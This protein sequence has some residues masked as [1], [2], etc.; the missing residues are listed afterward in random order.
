MKKKNII[1]V[2]LSL[3]VLSNTL[4]L[5]KNQETTM[6]S[7]KAIETYDMYSVYVDDNATY[8]YEYVPYLGIIIAGCETL[9]TELVFPDEIG[10]LPVTYINSAGYLGYTPVVDSTSCPNLKS[11]VIPESVTYV[12]WF[13]LNGYPMDITIQNPNTWLSLQ[14]NFNDITIHGYDDCSLYDTILSSGEYGMEYEIKFEPLPD[15]RKV[16]DNMKY[17]VTDENTIKIVQ[18]DESATEVN[19]PS[20]IDGMP[21][22]DVCSG[23]FWNCS[24]LASVTI[25]DSIVNI[26]NHAFQGCD[27][28]SVTI[29][30]SVKNI[31]IA[32]FSNCENLNSAVLPDNIES[33]GDSVF[34]DCTSLNSIV[35]PDGVKRIGKNAF[36]NCTSLTNISIPNSVTNIEDEAFYGCTSLTNIGISDSVTNIG[37]Y[38]FSGCTFLTSVTIPDSVTNIGNNAFSEC[39]S[40]TSITIPDSVKS[41]GYYV[42][43]E[44]P[45]LAD[46]Q[47]FVHNNVLIEV[48]RALEG[49][50]II[51]DKVTEI[52][53]NAL[54]ECSS[55]TSVIIPDSVTSIGEFAFAN[56]NLTEIKIP[57]SVTS[58]GN[59]AFEYCRS[60]KSVIL[61]NSVT[62]IGDSVF[63]SCYSL[64]T[65]TIPDSV[66]NIG[67]YA[68]AFSG[69]TII[70][71]PSSVANI[72]NNAFHW[73]DSLESITIEN[74]NCKIYDS[75]ST[76]NNDSDYNSDI[77]DYTYIFNG[78]I[79][80]YN[81]ST[82]QAYAEKCGYQ[83]E[84]LGEAPKTDKTGDIDNNSIIDASDASMVLAL[85]SE[86]STGL[87]S[88]LSESLK[89]ISDINKDGKIDAVDASLILDYYSYVSTGDTDSIEI[90][91]GKQA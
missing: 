15:N 88:D 21:V 64:K 22:T 36:E 4:I 28:I 40:L 32:A 14:N 71:L 65:V 69:L 84:S 11:M 53:D 9:A 74:Q 47:Y 34:S 33:I 54:N 46:R 62:S 90:F 16:Y 72:E 87:V 49:E 91:L 7:A 50:L 8:M 48:D 85:Y 81:N 13:A 12:G 18:C 30:D 42:L 10:G 55:L 56:L 20:E 25:P 35:I 63:G 45:W 76:I 86:L 24:N 79:Y 26:G 60:L 70:T 61:S 27:L 44:T 58:I 51:P 83:F 59:D 75:M 6:I 1:G 41:I 2:G 39:T 68:F 43:C 80:G 23:A 77:Q 31:G 19:I 82:A 37:N 17:V 67:K 52:G 3:L 78:T 29:P 5:P 38:A 66:N 89:A 73:C 57:D